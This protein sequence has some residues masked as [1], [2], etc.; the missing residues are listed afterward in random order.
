ME[1]THSLDIET[2][3]KE[4]LEGKDAAVILEQLRQREASDKFEIE[5]KVWEGRLQ[6]A[7]EKIERLEQEAVKVQAESEAQIVQL[8]NQNEQ[9]KTRFESEKRAQDQESLAREEKLREVEKKLRET[10]RTNEKLN[11]ECEQRIL[12]KEQHTR[13]EQRRLQLETEIDQLRRRIDYNQDVLE[14]RDKEIEKLER[15]LQSVSIFKLRL[16]FIPFRRKRLPEQLKM[17]SDTC[18][19]STKTRRKS[20]QTLWNWKTRNGNWSQS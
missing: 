19:K 20:D 3:A 5:Q 4:Q 8:S 17:S 1:K 14:K 6:D 10:E 16:I 9:L 18:V 12:D 15:E 2:F 11:I 13:T 7:S